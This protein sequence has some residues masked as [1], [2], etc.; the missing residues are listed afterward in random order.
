M[1][2]GVMARATANENR[3]MMA[4]AVASVR[5]PFADLLMELS[6]LTVFVLVLL[7]YERVMSNER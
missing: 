7:Y 3:H 5:N 1:D 4:D 6:C 2:A